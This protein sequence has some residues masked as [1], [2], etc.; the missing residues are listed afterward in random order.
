MSTLAPDKPQ[1]P[2]KPSQKSQLLRFVAITIAAIGSLAVIIVFA[3]WLV[4]LPAVHAFIVEYPGYG[5]VR[6][7]APS[8]LPPWLNFQHFLNV[9]FMVLIIRTGWQVRTTQR[10]SAYWTRKNNGLI[11]TSGPPKKISLDL[12]LHLTLDALW[13][14]NGATFL[15]L[16][17]AT[18]QWMR[19]VPT[20]WDVLPNA[21]S[22]VLQYTS[23][24]WPLENG[25]NN[26]NSLQLLSYFATVFIAAPLAFLSGLRMSNA[27][28][29]S[30]R[31]NKAYPIEL[32]RRLHFPVMI[33]FVVFIAVHVTLVLCTGALRNLNHMY[34]AADDDGWLGFA[35]F[36]AS[37]VVI[38]GSW[39]L[40]RPL[41]LRPIASLMGKVGR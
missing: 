2:E 16:L 7:D 33:Y 37:L 21:L 5:S 29:R 1:R 26:Y 24:D 4:S 35:L 11:K 14:L 9:F 38:V 27:W 39:F 28:P 18:G 19:V 25:W 40:A 15:V 8:G 12:W 36:A 23:L 31:L 20:S 10:P 41:F 34:A 22:A 30:P 3:R 13:I 17:L 32:A 6:M